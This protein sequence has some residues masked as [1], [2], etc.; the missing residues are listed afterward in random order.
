M[1][2]TVLIVVLVTVR[3]FSKSF[4]TY[5]QVTAVVT[6]VNQGGLNDIVIS[7]KNVRGIHY[8]SRVN[9]NGLRVPSLRK[10]LLNTE[11]NLSFVKPGILSGGLNPMTDKRQIAETKLENVLVYSLSPN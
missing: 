10:Q 2:C 5:S 9:T 7:L 11:I 8:I 6:K 1:T 4:N 3:P